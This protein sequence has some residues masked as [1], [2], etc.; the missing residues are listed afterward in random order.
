MS[1]T[2]TFDMHSSSFT[3]IFICMTIYDNKLGPRLLGNVE[4][5]NLQLFSKEDLH[6]IVHDS[7][8]MRT[9]KA[10]IFV[11]DLGGVPYRVY[12][13]QYRE[14]FVGYYFKGNKY[15]TCVFVPEDISSSVEIRKTME[16]FQWTEYIDSNGSPKYLR[17]Y[18]YSTIELNRV[19]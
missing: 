13:A 16:K 12:I 5:W 19:D 15:A 8:L 6:A 17:E 1:S 2:T 11:K 7:M 10:I 3:K 18:L 14:N 9:S 4:D